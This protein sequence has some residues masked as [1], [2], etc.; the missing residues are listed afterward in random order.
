VNWVLGKLSG[1]YRK[2]LVKALRKVIKVYYLF[3]KNK[4]LLLIIL[5][6]LYLNKRK[7]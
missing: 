2:P 1:A 6:T 3:K 5:L 4:D 7:V